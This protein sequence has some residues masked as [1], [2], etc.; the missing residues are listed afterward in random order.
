MESTAKKRGLFV[1]GVGICFAV[2]AVAILME[3]LIPGGT[4]GSG[5]HC[6]VYRYNY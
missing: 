1:P 2:A 3:H 4:F 6:P 5:Y